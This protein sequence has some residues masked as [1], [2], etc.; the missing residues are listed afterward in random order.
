[1]AAV[2]DMVAIRRTLQSIVVCKN[3]FALTL[4]LFVLSA[5]NGMAQDSITASATLNTSSFSVDNAALLT[6]TV[7]GT[8]SAEITLPETDGFELIQRGSSKQF[9]L[10]NGQYSSSITFTCLVRA[11]R[12]GNYNISPI[13]IEAEGRTIATTSIPFTVTGEASTGGSG[14]SPA[15]RSVADD[16][17]RPAFMAVT[18][19]K[20]TAYIGELFPIEIKAFFKR[21]IRANLTSLPEL[22]GDGLVMTQLTDKPAQTQETVDGIVYNVLTWRTNLSTIKVGDH[23]FRLELQAVEHVPQKRMSTSFFGRQSPFDD[24]F[25]DSMLGGYTQRPMKL[26]SKKRSLTVLPLPEE[27]LPEDFSGAIG[28]FHVHAYAE[29]DTVELGE[30][31]TLTISVR[32]QG[33]FDRVGPPSFPDNSRGIWRIYSPGSTF[34]PADDSGLTGE[35]IFEQAVVARNSDITEI[36]ALSFTYFDPDR[37]V[38]VSTETRPVP[39]QIIKSP[40]DIPQASAPT[41][42]PSVSQQ[43]NVPARQ[44]TPAKDTEA[45]TTV[46]AVSGLAP[47]HLETGAIS[48]TIR[49]VYDK[50]PFQLYA[51]ACVLLTV[52][53]AILKVR[54]LQARGTPEEQRRRKRKSLLNSSIANLKQAESGDC[55]AYLNQCRAV[56]QQHL[57]YL[58]QCEPAA[59]TS[60]SAT[61]RL[62]QGSPLAE[63]LKRAEHA[64]YSGAVLSCEEMAETTQTVK[65]ELENLL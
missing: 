14:A 10:I 43:G 25:F 26:A 46:P 52:I 31:M 57:G 17:S 9:N 37:G 50:L 23:P 39:I 19:P 34:H 20:D 7:N 5:A 3:A 16:T 32:G 2:I 36:P 53:A 51:L 64:V 27:G 49:P 1:M 47:L 29:P 35:K 12:P 21:G 56:I 13:T 38:Y 59:I 63:V 6:I 18:L 11:L 28:K 65:R 4:C 41:V 54:Q 45:D 58:W 24:D 55:S 42:Q 22:A 30:P 60:A 61:S 8:R 44:T 62:P 33:N 40:T 15:T 48:R